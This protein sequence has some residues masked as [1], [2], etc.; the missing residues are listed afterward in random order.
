M[1]LAIAK[2]G[3]RLTCLFKKTFE[4]DGSIFIE[5]GTPNP[6]YLFRKVK[7]CEIKAKK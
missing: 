5:T 7:R 4:I 1:L 3:N 6:F 2:L